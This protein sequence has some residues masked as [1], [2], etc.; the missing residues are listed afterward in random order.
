MHG[1]A[2]GRPGKDQIRILRIQSYYLELD[3]RTTRKG[4]RDDAGRCLGLP[5]GKREQIEH[6]FPLA[7]RNVFLTCAYH[8]V[9]MKTCADTL[10]QILP[11]IHIL[12]AEA[13]HHQRE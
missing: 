1:L 8:I 2:L 4:E 11:S 3:F 10:M 6:T 7:L 13:V 5:K 9:K 12:P